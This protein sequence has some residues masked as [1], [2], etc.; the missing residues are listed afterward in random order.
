MQV[1]NEGY[2]DQFL[3]E[4]ERSLSQEIRGQP[5]DYILN[6][7]ADEFL[8][9]VGSRYELNVPE[10]LRDEVFVDTG[11]EMVPAERFPFSFNVHPGSSG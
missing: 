11:E 3:E 1:F 4:R 2:F 9:Y 8:A 5:E 7:N 10:L 6:V